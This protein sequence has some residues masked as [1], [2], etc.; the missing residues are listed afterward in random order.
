MNKN[1]YNSLLNKYPNQFR[2]IKHI[3]CGDG[4]FD[5]LEKACGLI[6][7]HIDTKNKKG[8]DIDFHWL[9]IKEKFGYMRAYHSGGDDYIYGVVSMLES[10]SSIICEYSGEKGRLRKQRIDDNGQQIPAWIKTLSDIEAQKER[11]V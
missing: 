6:E 1:L 10:I 2:S 9:Q 8:S 3:E 11:Y 4:W 5:I 7:W